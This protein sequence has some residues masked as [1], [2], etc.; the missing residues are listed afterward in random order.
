MT[1]RLSN[2]EVEEVS[3]VTSPA[4]P[5][6][7]VVLVKMDH[8]D[9]DWDIE[10]EQP[11]SSDVH[12]DQPIGK[13]GMDHGA[14]KK[15]EKCPECGYVAKSRGL[16][17]K[18]AK[19]PVKGSEEDLSEDD[20]ADPDTVPSGDSEEDMPTITQEEYDKVVAERDEA[21]AQ[22][23]AQDEPKE[24]PEEEPEGEEPT[25]EKVLKGATPEVQ[26]VF[27]KIQKEADDNRAAAEAAMKI[28]KA[29]QDT[30]LTRE[31]IEKARVEYGTVA[32]PNELGPV[33]KSLG[34]TDPEALKAVEK[35][36]AGA[37]TMARKA[38]LF[39]EIGALGGTDNDTITKIEGVAK[40]LQESDP[41]LS[42]EQAL[43]KAWELNPTLYAEYIA[44]RG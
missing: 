9:D 24:E 41:K 13:C 14:M 5:E 6:A 19:A 33:L 15:G 12:I 42:P 11:G 35:V 36:L 23:A 8:T 29:E 26:A 18:G 25:V 37:E 32:N 4:N 10:K 34:E 17:R 7:R 20:L 28:A 3:F 21:L 31:A 44:E 38:K 1:T 16:F 39:G 27:A 40:G 43:A 2:V 22:V 30:R